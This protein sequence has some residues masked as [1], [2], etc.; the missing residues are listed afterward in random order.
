MVCIAFV[1]LLDS[2]STVGIYEGDG[3]FDTSIMTTST[4]ECYQVIMKVCG[5]WWLIGLLDMWTWCLNS[6]LNGIKSF[7]CSQLLLSSDWAV[8]KSRSIGSSR[9]RVEVKLTTILTYEDLGSNDFK[10]I[11]FL[12]LLSLDNQTIIY[13]W[14]VHNV[15]NKKRS[16]LVAQIKSSR[17][18]CILNWKWRLG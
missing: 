18:S 1:N 15:K 9:K 6:G 14:G 3:L 11:H 5:T 8:G 12:V 16:W 10:I 17:I 2:S 7:S 13:I 4:R